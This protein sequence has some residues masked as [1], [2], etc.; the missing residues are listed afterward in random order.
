MSEQ[1]VTSPGEHD[2]E[3]T[4]CPFNGPLTSLCTPSSYMN[5]SEELGGFP[6]AC[7]K[8]KHLQKEMCGWE[9]S[10]CEDHMTGR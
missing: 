5:V 4:E 2:K 10:A 7:E 8:L 3:K 9:Q 6:F 1:E